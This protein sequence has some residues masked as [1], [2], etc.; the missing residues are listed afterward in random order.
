V[1]A[2][3]G[4]LV[5]V[6]QKEIFERG[7]TGPEGHPLS[8]PPEVEGEAANRARASPRCWG[9]ALR[10]AH[11]L[12]RRPGGHHPGPPRRSAVFAEVLAQHLVIDD[13]VYQNPD[14]DTPRR[15]M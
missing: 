7:F 5:Y 11:L 4:E 14:W 1:H 10:R 2:E 9:A 3:N 12:H 13:S 6:L 8:R 15:T